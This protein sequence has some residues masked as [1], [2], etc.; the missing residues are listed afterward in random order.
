MM[1]YI[2]LAIFVLMV[3]GCSTTQPPVTE[4][5][6]NAT[7]SEQKR[8]VRGCLDKS[9]KV[10]QAFSSSSLM[11]QDMN[12]GLGKSK[13]YVYSQS[14]WADVPNRALTSEIV[15]LL[16]EI[17]LFKNIQIA[18]SRSKSN[19]I[20]ETYIED[21]KQ[22]FNDDSSSSYANVVVSLGILDAKSNKIVA[23]KTFQSKVDVKSLDAGGGVEALNEALS[24][25]LGQSAEWFEDVCK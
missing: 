24:Q 14:Q 20:L 10:A 4:Y 6:I 7:L 3:S 17:K 16:R 2:F 9:I 1:K 13:Q 21:F 18:K 11:S 25:V 12:Y 22:Y 23:S 8:D 15:K 19:L 5:R